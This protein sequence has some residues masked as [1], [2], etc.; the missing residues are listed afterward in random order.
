MS[1]QRR[2]V[3]LKN[4]A[5]EKFFRKKYWHKNSFLPTWYQTFYEITS[6]PHVEDFT[7]LFFCSVKLMF[8]GIRDPGTK[9]CYARKCKQMYL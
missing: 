2:F 4:L 1:T 9:M 3:I 6:E 8:M 7:K 5:Y